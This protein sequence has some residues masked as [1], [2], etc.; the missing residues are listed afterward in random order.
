MLFRRNA[1]SFLSSSENGSVP[2]SRTVPDVGGSS[3][4]KIDSSVLFPEPLGPRIA[5]FSPR[6]SSNE[7][8]ERIR[9]GS[10]GVGYSLMIS[11]TM[12]SAAAP[13]FIAE[14]LAL[15]ARHSTKLRSDFGRNRYRDRHAALRH[16]AADARHFASRNFAA[17]VRER[18]HVREALRTDSLHRD[19][20]RKLF[21]APRR[22]MI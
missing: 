7:T 18:E 4:P 8:P 15:R 6:H 12:S 1:A 13:S 14:L 9:R 3:V 10:A 22:R 17:L 5:T 20:D 2:P 16:S 19:L 11:S 21:F